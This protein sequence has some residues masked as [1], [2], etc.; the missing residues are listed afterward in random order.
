MGLVVALVLVVA[1]AFVL[2]TRGVLPAGQDAMPGKL[3]TWAARTSLAAAIGR[4]ARGLT[5]P[6]QPTEANLT[7]GAGLY[8]THCQICHGGP[9]AEMSSIARGLTP[10][11]P[12]LAKD[13]VEDDP[14]GTIYW[15]IAHGIRFTGMP[16]FR[17]SMSESEMWQVALFVK[18][19]DALPA[20]TGAS[21]AA[22]S[23]R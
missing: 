23:T 18:H 7:A 21:W 3:E 16:S 11:P 22:T 9:T 5:S 15:K 19:L 4:G 2:V 10:N 8:V 6:L 13:G 20:G 14:V 12:Q 17:G 1:S